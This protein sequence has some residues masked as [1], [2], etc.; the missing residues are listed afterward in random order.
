MLFDFLADEGF[1]F[2][3]WATMIAV[4]IPVLVFRKEL[5]GMIA[6][7]VC[8]FVVNLFLRTNEP[9]F[10]WLDW[11]G[12]SFTVGWTIWFAYHFL[13]YLNKE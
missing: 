2:Q 1:Q 6:A 8:I 4:I 10:F 5:H 3:F 7:I 9:V 13:R 12:I 11:Y